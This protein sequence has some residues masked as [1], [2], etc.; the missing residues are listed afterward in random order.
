MKPRIRPS[1]YYSRTSDGV[2]WL[3]PGGLIKLT[4]SA[5]AELTER[6]A[7][8]LTGS[9]S[10]DE[11]TAGLSEQ[12]AHVVNSLINSLMEC[13]LVSD[14]DYTS[15]PGGPNSTFAAWHDC[16]DER[17]RHGRGI[18]IGAS[19]V[20]EDFREALA[21]SG[22]EDVEV[23]S[24]PSI[25]HTSKPDYAVHI[26]S[27]NDLDIAAQIEGSCADIPLVQ[28]MIGGQVAIF[29]MPDGIGWQSVWSRLRQG[30]RAQIIAPTCM[31]STAIRLL[32]NQV[33]FL[34]YRAIIGVTSVASGSVTWFNGVT[35]N[36]T[37]HSV[38]LHPSV[39]HAAT[40]SPEEFRQAITRLR[41][42][43]PLDEEEFSRNVISAI[44]Q[45][46]GPILALD[47]GELPQIPVRQARAVLDTGTVVERG[48]D[49]GGTRRR[50]ALRALGQY[51]ATAIDSRRLNADR[52]LWAWRPHDNGTCLVRQPPMVS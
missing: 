34:L 50:T 51:A 18:A 19:T 35:L 31:N 11:L 1:S 46:F 52:K 26:F 40:E 39:V 28:V 16:S 13:G 22:A 6:L 3:G 9:T 20:V 23:I 5:I 14:A 12:Q 37:H 47:E 21:A 27:A 33:C 8:S 7:P 2:A 10:M 15:A 17:Y 45:R 42:E 24:D 48:A 43:M 4:G 49:F 29:K 30:D 41:K 44:D 38:L 36:S 25:L 32:A